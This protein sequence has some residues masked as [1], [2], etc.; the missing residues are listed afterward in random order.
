[1]GQMNVD[2]LNAFLITAFVAAIIGN[3]LVL[4]VRLR[5]AW[6]TQMTAYEFLIC[7]LATTD[8]QFAAFIPIIV[9]SNVKGE[10]TLGETSCQVLY[11]WNNVCLTVSILNVVLMGYERYRSLCNP[12]GYR[13]TRRKTS[14]ALLFIWLFSIV[15]N[16][17]VFVV[18]KVDVFCYTVYPNKTAQMVNTIELF[19]MQYLLPIVL[20][21]ILNA[22]VIMAMRQRAN[23]VHISATSSQQQQQENIAHSHMTTSVTIKHD[24]KSDIAIKHDNRSDIA[25][26]HDNR[27]DIAKRE[28]NVDKHQSYGVV[29]PNINLK[30]LTTSHLQSSSNEHIL[31]RNCNQPYTCF[32]SINSSTVNPTVAT[33]GGN[34]RTA[35]SFVKQ[36]R[37]VFKILTTL[38]VAHMVLSLPHHIY[39]LVRL[40]GVTISDDLDLALVGLGYMTYLNGCVN[41]VLYSIFDKRFR[42]DVKKLFKSICQTV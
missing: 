12:L 11:T 25:I 14:L 36:Y 19:L 38:T 30:T 18:M 3:A 4:I 27:S 8:L 16:I 29:N 34:M 5:K 22:K 15:I 20:M 35:E 13:W 40:S 28:A 42:K 39:N 23:A 24:N 41:P 6:A 37:S 33:A 9:Y 32:S 1:M 10:W 17:G 7:H 2:G 21:V 31:N 26:K